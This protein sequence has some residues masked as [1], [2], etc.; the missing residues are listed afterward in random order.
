[1]DMDRLY[2]L[3]AGRFESE[4]VPTYPP[5]IEDLAVIVGESTP[6]AEVVNAILQS[7]GFLL[8]RADLFDIFRGEQVGAGNKS[9]AYRLTWQAPNRTL[10][11]QE[12]G[13][14]REKVIQKLEK[15]LKAK[16]RKAE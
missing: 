4:S 13:K 2:S 10:N 5:V 8:K 12:V 15:E 16:V 3:S 14:L 6:N 11:D 7:G 9:L 1:L